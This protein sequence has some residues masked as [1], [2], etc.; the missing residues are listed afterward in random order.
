MVSDGVAKL[1]NSYWSFYLLWR[2]CTTNAE[3]YVNGL[4]HAS[5]R[6]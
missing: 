4:L 5:L 6:A 2:L 3:R 1:D